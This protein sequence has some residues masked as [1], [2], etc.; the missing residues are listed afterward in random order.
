MWPWESFGRGSPY[1][2]VGVLFRGS[3]FPRES[4]SVG[5]MWPWESLGRG[6]PYVAVGVLGRLG[7][8][9]CERLKERNYSLESI[10]ISVARVAALLFAQVL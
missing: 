10:P 7:R 9:P 8:V 3:P 6:S 4:F 5:V 2:A 1:V